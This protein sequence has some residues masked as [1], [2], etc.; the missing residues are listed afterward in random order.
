MLFFPRISELKIC[1][2]LSCITATCITHLI[3]FDLMMCIML[4]L[5]LLM[6][7]MMTMM[8]R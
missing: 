7:M 6:M 1:G 2:L 8:R 3:S 5:L 4:L